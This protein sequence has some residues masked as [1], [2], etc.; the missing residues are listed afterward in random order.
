R[1]QVMQ[2]PELLCRQWAGN[3]VDTRQVAAWAVE[4][5]DQADLN[6]VDPGVEDDG[7]RRGRRLG[8][9]RGRAVAG[10]KYGDLLANQFRRQ[11]RQAIVLTLR[12]TVFDR[13]VLAFDKPGFGQ[14]LAERGQ[15][16]P[17]L[18]ERRAAEEPDHRHRRLL[19]ARRERPGRCA[20]EQ[21]YELAAPHSI[22][23][24]ARSRN[25]RLIV[26]PRFFAVLRL[27][28]SSNLIGSWTG[29]S[30]G[31]SPLRMRSTYEADRRKRS[32]TSGPYDAN[33]PAVM[34]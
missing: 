21:R 9:Q 22:T 4:T 7:N 23:S 14:S 30:P 17:T 13:D 12:P 29:R 18:R 19:R 27:I 20:A 11:S 15:Q 26:R 25:S 6:R 31:F 2:K 34:K 8:R 24:S 5:R 28:T 16:R 32:P 3:H 33:P 1:H 10:D